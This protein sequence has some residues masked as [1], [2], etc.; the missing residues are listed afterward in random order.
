MGNR[1]YFH[2]D[3]VNRNIYNK[4]KRLREI[5]NLGGKENE[6]EKNYRNHIH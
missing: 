4:A 6:E 2:V 3:N 1:I 5:K